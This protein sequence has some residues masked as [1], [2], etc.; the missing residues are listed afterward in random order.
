MPNKLKPI[1][2][3]GRPIRKTDNDIT[4]QHLITTNALLKNP[5][6]QHDRGGVFRYDDIADI[7]RRYS[8]DIETDLT[9][10][11]RMMLFNRAINNTDDHKRNF[12]LM[13]KGNSYCLSPAYDMVPLW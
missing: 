13:H 12:S 4:R 5:E 7:V 9:Q 8:I 10:L 6:T 3:G 11:L 1:K 2:S